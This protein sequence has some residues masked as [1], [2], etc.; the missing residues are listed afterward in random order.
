MYRTAVRKDKA[1]RRRVRHRAWIRLSSMLAD[2]VF[3]LGG[4]GKAS[5][6]GRPATCP[7]KRIGILGLPARFA[8]VFSP[9]ALLSV[10]RSALHAQLLPIGGILIP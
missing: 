7:P 4:V 1:G 6:C 9:F 10:Q 2:Q 5:R 8:A 3:G